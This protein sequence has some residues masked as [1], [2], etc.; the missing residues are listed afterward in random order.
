MDELN[1]FD[2]SIQVHIKKYM[3]HAVYLKNIKNT[4]IVHCDFI[5]FLVPTFKILYS[6][7]G[8]APLVLK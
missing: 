6:C 5:L 7:P 4:E 8:T 2:N 3:K 1:I